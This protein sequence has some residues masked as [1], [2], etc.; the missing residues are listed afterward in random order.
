MKIMNAL[1][2]PS[3]ICAIISEQDASALLIGTVIGLTA[4]SIIAAVL[5]I[6]PYLRKQE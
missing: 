5:W 4:L 1:F 6:A 2:G 3:A